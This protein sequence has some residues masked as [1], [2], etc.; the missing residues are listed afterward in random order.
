MVNIAAQDL[1]YQDYLDEYPYLLTLS[2]IEAGQTG[3]LLRLEWG[4]AEVEE[5]YQW[6][7]YLIYQ[8]MANAPLTKLGSKVMTE[9]GEE[10]ISRDFFLYLGNSVSA[11]YLRIFSADLF[12]ADYLPFRNF[13]FSADLSFTRSQKYEYEMHSQGSYCDFFSVSPWLGGW[14]PGKRFVFNVKLG[15]R[16]NW[17]PEEMW[18]DY[19]RENAYLFEP[20]IKLGA[21][22]K[23]GNGRVLTGLGI[24]AY[25]DMKAGKD[26][27]MPAAI[28][29]ALS[30]RIG[31]AEKK[32]ATPPAGVVVPW[33]ED[34]SADEYGDDDISDDGISD[35]DEYSDAPYEDAI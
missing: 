3:E 22:A 25:F 9:V 21:Y 15:G 35:G 13:G 27:Y 29:F 2:L 1:A 4:Y 19:H 30:W 32:L 8:A 26:Y 11:S 28:E 14:L 5:M 6:T 24:N 31:L 23:A 16:L 33:E 20:G 17:Y 7:L 10:E 12:Q 34:T 18:R